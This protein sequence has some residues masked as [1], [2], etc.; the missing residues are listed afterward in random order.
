[1]KHIFDAVSIRFKEGA[2]REFAAKV[3]AGR[4]SAGRG[5]G[6]GKLSSSKHLWLH[7]CLPLPTPPR[8]AARLS[9][10]LPLPRTQVLANQSMIDECVN[11][12]ETIV[13]QLAGHELGH[14]A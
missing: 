4:A 12:T 13:Y 3:G 9:R 1:M 8:N 5:G 10:S 6:T 14:G 11:T 2:V 7:G